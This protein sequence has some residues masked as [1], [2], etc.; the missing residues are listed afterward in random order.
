MSFSGTLILLFLA[1][2]VISLKYSKI[3]TDLFAHYFLQDSVFQCTLSQEFR[4]IICKKNDLEIN[5]VDSQ[6]N[7]ATLGTSFFITF[8]CTHKNPLF[9][10]IFS[11]DMVITF[12]PT[13]TIGIFWTFITFISK[14]KNYYF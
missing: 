13:N 4:D 9:C 1:M 14:E 5:Y 6:I 12:S 11:D 2:M 7:T 3:K 8:L 10:Y